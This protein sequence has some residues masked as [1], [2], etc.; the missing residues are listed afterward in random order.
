MDEVRCHPT[1]PFRC[2]GGTNICI[3]IQYLCDGAPDCPDGYDEDSRLCTAGTC[4]VN[5]AQEIVNK[6]H[7]CHIE[8]VE[9]TQN[10]TFI[11]INFLVKMLSVYGRVGIW[12]IAVVN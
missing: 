2:P 9:V 12:G 7:F 8:H 4:P 6:I 5:L 11:P 10:Q 1:Q 3:S